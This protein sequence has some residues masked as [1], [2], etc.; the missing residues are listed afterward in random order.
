MLYS[1]Y[2]YYCNSVLLMIYIIYISGGFSVIFPNHV[3]LNTGALFRSF[4]IAR[5]K[6]DSRG[7]SAALV[8]LD[9][10]TW[11][12]RGEQVHARG[13]PKLGTPD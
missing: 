5:V 10:S 6:P 13:G 1:V 7:P 12:S 11:W 4:E 9:P 3:S 8:F 2:N